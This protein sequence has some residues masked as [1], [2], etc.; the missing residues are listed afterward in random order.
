M[1]ENT[2]I[3]IKVVNSDEQ[4]SPPTQEEIEAKLRQEGYEVYCWT[5]LP[6]VVYPRHKHIEDQCIWIIEGELEF[7]VGEQLYNL[8]AGDRIYLP[9]NIA[10]MVK[11]PKLTSATY[12]VGK[13]H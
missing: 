1:S 7:Q 2:S 12:V 5:D 6:G 10:H 11:T 13:K 4:Q 9:S 8:H 3:T